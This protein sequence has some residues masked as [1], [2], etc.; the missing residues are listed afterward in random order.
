MF[1]SLEQWVIAVLAIYACLLAL[2]RDTDT[3][4]RSIIG[5]LLLI[6]VLLVCVLRR[7]G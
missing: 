7:M 2:G 3:L 4:L 6:S 1:S 5:T